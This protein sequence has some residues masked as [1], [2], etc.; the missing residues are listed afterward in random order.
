[1]SNFYFTKYTVSIWWKSVGG[2]FFCETAFEWCPYASLIAIGLWKLHQ[3]IYI[4][5]CHSCQFWWFSHC[6]FVHH[7]AFDSSVNWTMRKKHIKVQYNS[8][9]HGTKRMVFASTAKNGISVANKGNL[10]SA[11]AH[12]QLVSGVRK[13]EANLESSTRALYMPHYTYPKTLFHIKLCH[14]SIFSWCFVLEMNNL[15]FA[16]KLLA[17]K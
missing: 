14:I 4:F 16:C 8:V 6:S 1:M 3:S 17:S 10:V 11:V 12:M 9:G 13:K 15:R 7:K 2:S 5:V